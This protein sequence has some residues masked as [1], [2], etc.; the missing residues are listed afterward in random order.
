MRRSLL[1]RIAIPF[2]VLIILTVG[3]ISI[4]FSNYME[5]TYLDNLKIT[6]QTDG[7]LLAQYAL[8]L[9]M[10]GSPSEELDSLV[11][12]YADVIN[13]RITIILSD[14]RVIGE[15]QT[16]FRDLENLFNLPEVRQALES[17]LGWQIRM[18]EPANRRFFYLAVPIKTGN[19]VVGIVRIGHSLQRIETDLTV[20]RGT[21]YVAGA[22]TIVLVILMAVVVAN[23]TILPLRQLSREVSRLS[24]GDYRVQLPSNRKD[25]IGLLSQTFATMATRLNEQ[26]EGYREE[27]GKLDAILRHMTDAIIIV[28]QNGLVTLINPA[29]ER[30]FNISKNNALGRSLV[31]VARQHQVV[32]LWKESKTSQ[33]QQI[34]TIETSPHRLIVQGIATPLEKS[35]PGNT[36]LVFQDL[37]RVRRLETVRRDFVSNVS[38]ELRTPLASLKALTETLHEGALEDPPAARRFLQRMDLEIDNMTQLVRELLELS[39]I[40]SGKVPFNRQPVMPEDLLQ[41]AVERMQLQAERGK[42]QLHLEIQDHLP[43]VLADADRIEQVV[44]NLLH[45]AIKFTPPGGD[46]TAQARQEGGFVIFSIQDNGVGIAPEALSRIFERFYKADQS[47]SGG[48]TGLGLSIARHTIEAHDGRIWAESDLHRGSKF[49]FSLPLA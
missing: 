49:Y 20:L 15:S 44:V 38:H 5:R 48:G 3:G 16:D 7:Q 4:Y 45:N 32:D 31:E 8:P 42:L 26:I 39:R 37:T 35:M 28:D 43:A 34:T 19:E 30:I 25:E 2:I 14:G 9:V 18:E 6:L 23:R 22:L 11:Q 1:W 46:I 17:G 40:E 13:A 24:L 29:A 41:S 27:R 10:K 33:R 36:L 12:N 21:I 47:R